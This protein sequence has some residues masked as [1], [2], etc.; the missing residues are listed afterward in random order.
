ML[1]KPRSP[2]EDF[3]NSQTI[4]WLPLRSEERVRRRWFDLVFH[5]LSGSASSAS[6]L[7]RASRHLATAPQNQHRS[8]A[9][10]HP[11]GSKEP[12]RS[13]SPRSRSSEVNERAIQAVQ[14]SEGLR[15][16]LPARPLA[17]LSPSCGPLLALSPNSP[18]VK[19]E[20]PHH[21]RRYSVESST[22]AALRRAP[23]KPSVRPPIP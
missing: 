15:T 8:P 9:S 14:I 19:H 6:T 10:S 21:L 1:E 23:R 3:R 13:L 7:R 16:P 17:Q 2:R 5:Q 11:Q 12:F 4:L 22:I 20:T 18:T